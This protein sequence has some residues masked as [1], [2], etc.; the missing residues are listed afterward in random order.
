MEKKSELW[1][2]LKHKKKFYVSISLASLNNQVKQSC[3]V[4]ALVSCA[5]NDIKNAVL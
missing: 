5:N 1:S 2:K 4:D 3:K